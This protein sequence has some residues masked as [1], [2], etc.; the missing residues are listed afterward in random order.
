MEFHLHDDVMAWKHFLRYWPF[1]RGIQR[2]PVNFPHKG[3]VMW[4]FDC[5][6]NTEQTVEQPV[7]LPVIWDAITPMWRHCNVMQVSPPNEHRIIDN[8][9]WYQRYQPV[10]YK[11][12]SRSGNEQEF[13]DMVERCNNAGVRWVKKK[14]VQRTCDAITTSLKRH[15]YVMCPLEHWTQYIEGTDADMA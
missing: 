9:P 11:L 8:H 14:Y 6:L 12:V 13:K 7:K 15:R 10:S 4:C 3:P 2:S 1:V 5:F